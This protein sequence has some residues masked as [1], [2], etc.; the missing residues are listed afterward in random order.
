MKPKTKDELIEGI[1][2]VWKAVN[3]QEC[4]KY[5]RHLR[6]VIPKVI[7]KHGEATGY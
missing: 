3:K 7:E 6:K 4:A 2:E 5:T 1:K